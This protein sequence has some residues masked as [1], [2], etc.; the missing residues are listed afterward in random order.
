[1]CL[2]RSAQLGVT[3]D[4]RFAMRSNTYR[5][6]RGGRGGVQPHHSRGKSLQ[7]QHIGDCFPL[8]CARTGQARG[9]AP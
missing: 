1:M 3:P 4:T 2:S 9:D 5:R 7:T 6:M 8:A